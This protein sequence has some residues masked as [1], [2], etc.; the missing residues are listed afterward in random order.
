MDVWE[1]TP[2]SKVVLNLPATVEMATPNI[3]ADQIEWFHR[4]ISRRDSVIL[5]PHP[6]NDR[7]TA[8]AAA[9]Q[10]VMAGGDRGE[11]SLVRHGERTRHDC[12][13]TPAPDLFSQGIHPGPDLTHT[14]EARRPVADCDQ[15]AVQP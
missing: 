12:P 11:G 10:G 4:N 8:V 3:Y 13:V 2:D 7:G 6:H 5:S 1:P 9:E 14:D 15:L